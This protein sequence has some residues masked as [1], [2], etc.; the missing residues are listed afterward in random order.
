MRRGASHSPSGPSL[1]P[2]GEKGLPPVRPPDSSFHTPLTPTPLHLA[3]S[4]H[5]SLRATY[6]SIAQVLLVSIPYHS[7]TRLPRIQCPFSLPDLHFSLCLNSS[8]APKRTTFATLRAASLVALPPGVIA[9]PHEESHGT[10]DVNRPTTTSLP[11]I[12]AESEVG[13]YRDPDPVSLPLEKG[14]SLLSL[15]DRLRSTFRAF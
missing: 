1:A 10:A 2:A 12:L 5:C 9:P 6:V 3:S 13:K 7:K 8:T 4:L 11:A 14:A 15:D